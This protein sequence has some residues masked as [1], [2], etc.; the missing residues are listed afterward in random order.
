[1]IEKK[2]RK[3]SRAF[4]FFIQRNK[5]LGFFIEVNKNYLIAKRNTI[6]AKELCIPPPCH[7]S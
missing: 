2:R 4:L 1:M 6:T 7:I 5:K 3:L